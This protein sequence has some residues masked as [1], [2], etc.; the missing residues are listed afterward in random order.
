[1][2]PLVE[3]GRLTLATMDLD[4]RPMFWTEPG[5]T[6]R[7]YEPDV[8]GAA[9]ARLGLATRWVPLPWAQMLPALLAGACDAVWAC[10]A[11]TEERKA[12]VDFSV[13]YGRFDEAVVVRGDDPTSSPGDLAGRR[14][15]AISGSSNMALVESFGGAVPVTYDGSSHDVMREMADAVRLGEIDAFVDD[16]QVLTPY[17]EA[18]DDLR[19]AFVNP[20]R[21]AYGVAIRKESPALRA[22]IDAALGALLANG[23]LESIWRRWFPHRPPAF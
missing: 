4:G 10:Q 3:P 15:G 20:T 19:I 2:L 5:G 9:A 16:E 21:I 23:E 17:A 13:P 1:M 7:G 12:I 8:A 6:Q 18:S 14:V 22:A 11:I